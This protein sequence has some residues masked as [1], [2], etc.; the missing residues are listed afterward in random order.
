MGLA[1]SP[2]LWDL[3]EHRVSVL[4]ISHQGVKLLLKFKSSHK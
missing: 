1:Q 2:V 4:A 3:E